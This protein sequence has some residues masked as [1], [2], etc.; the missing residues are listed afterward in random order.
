MTF[1]WTLIAMATPVSAA[2]PHIKAVLVAETASPAPGQNVTLA[3]RMTPEPGWHG[4]WL[5]PGDA[6]LP[7]EVN[8]ALPQGLAAE[9]LR[10]PVPK[11][12]LVSGLM[13][14]V[15]KGE[16]ALLSRVT[17]P[18][19]LAAGASLPFRAKA[20]WLACT[21][22]ICVPEEGDLALDLVVGDGAVSAENQK[23][24]DIW[25]AVL[26]RPLG[27]AASFATDTGKVRIAIPYP[28]SRPTGTPWFFAETDRAVAYAAPQET[29]RTGDT[30]IIETKAGDIPPG[31]VLKGVLALEDGTGFAIEAKRGTVPAVGKLWA[32]IAI[33]LSGAILGGLLLNI[34]PC[35]FPIISL[36]AL[37]LARA[38]GDERAARRDALAY[39]VGVIL[40]CVALGGLLLGLR[41]TGV[42]VGWA[43]QLQNPW[44]IALL[45]L[46]CIAITANLLGLFHLR[47]FGGGE[48]LAGKGG[49]AGAFWTGV[50]A[51]FVATP[52]TGPFM[53]AA[54]GAA[55]VLPTAAALA[56][57]AGLGTGMAIPFLLI[58]FVP[59]L[60]QRL[61]KPG[62][63]MR[64]FQRFLAIPM[65]L[66]ALALG[67]LLWRQIGP[68]VAA[69]S[70]Y[71]VVPFSSAK[72][73]ALT[74]ANKPVFLYFTADWCITCKVNEA[75]AIDRAEVQS[76]F[77]K[78]GVTIMVGDW[79]N[80]DAAIT[81]FLESRGRSGVPLYLWYPVGA[82]EPQELPQVLTPGTLTGLLS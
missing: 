28:A 51:A 3:I 54:L 82:K 60:R 74:A 44:V 50:L 48:A 4:Y 5:N 19:S 66:T 10:Y 43:F 20:N 57:F 64:T 34:M 71:N 8:W 41:A 36:K 23:Q 14:H 61:P 32:S 52:C 76:A 21:D 22:K 27:S 33:A 55:L 69:V 45:L 7:M 25:R 79:T 15:F 56:I 49:T 72:L 58:G 65:A 12:L 39:S 11:T 16:Y 68:P 77:H 53:A 67:W 78:A 2:Q 13:N 18:K 59:S 62:Q 37:S 63:W 30:L 6:G 75:A 73:D 31:S 9:P 24:F 40:T 26:P 35:V 47:A 46:L 81:R 38:G 70:Q 80:G 17:I 29:T 42:A 1:L